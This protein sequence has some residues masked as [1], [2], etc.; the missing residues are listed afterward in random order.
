MSKLYKNIFIILLSVLP[1]FIPVQLKAQSE[2]YQ[3]ALWVR[4]ISN[5]VNWNNENKIQ[6]FTIGVYGSNTSVYDELLKLSKR[7]KIKGKPFEVIRFKRIKDIIPTQI[8]FVDQS[9]NDYLKEIY[10][11]IMFNTLLITDQSNQRNYFMVNLLP[12]SSGKKRV[13]LN[14]KLANNAGLTFERE[15]LV[16]GGDELE[17]RRMISKTEKALEREKKKLE[18]QK[19][20][21]AKQ[22]AELE[23]LK[24]E[25]RKEREENARQK[26][27]NKKQKAE[28]E[29][30]KQLLET[31]REELAKVLENLTL[32][33]EKLAMGTKVLAEQEDKMKEQEDLMLQ[34]QKELE[35][36]EAEIERSKEIIKTKDLTL[37]EQ[38]LTI[39]YQ[40]IILFVFI[41]LL[42]LIMYLAFSIWRSAKMRKKI[43]DELRERN[44]DIR[45]KNEEI[46]NQQRQTE[47][48][49]KELEKLSIVAARTD[50]AVTIMDADGNFE[51]V[52]VGFTRLYGYTLQLLTHE[53]GENIV[54]VSSSSNIK[55]LL[56]QCKREKKTVTYENLNKT[57]NGKE[58]WVQTSLT[59]ILDAEGN[60]NKLITIETNIDRIKQAEQEI[61]KQ[62]KKILEQ[63][64]ILEETNKELEKLSIVASETDNAITIMDAAGNYQWINDGFTRMFGYTFNQLL[65][66]YSRNIISRHTGKQSVELI[67]K[68]IEQVVPVTYETPAETREGKEIWVQTTITPITDKEGNV[69]NLISISTDISK[70]KEAEQAI[71]QQSEEL[72]AQKEE[73]MIKNEYIEQQNEN[74]KASITYAKTIQNAILPAYDE[75]TRFFNTFI[76][77]KPKDIVSGDFF[78]YSHLPEKDGYSEKFFYAAVD[79]TG[80]G[81]PGAFMSMIGSRL[82]NEIVNERKITKPSLILTQ[83]D[84]EVKTI[85]RQEETDNNDG[86]DVSLCMIERLPDNTSRILFAGAKRPLFYYLKEEQTLRYIKG[87]R[88]TIG[89]TQARRNRELFSDNELILKNGDVIYLTTDGLID[90]SSP[91]RIRY[92]TPRLIQLLQRISN[93]PLEEQK[94]MIEKSLQSFQGEEDQRDDVTFI[95]IQL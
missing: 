8:L 40:R 19:K 13:E 26:E 37:G 82:L 36:V 44:D 85:L 12:Q 84:E 59:P 25:N 31:Q 48:L 49:N 23:R 58:V 83:M 6:K 10:D 52:N 15:L 35:Q 73:L 30:Q 95:G 63:S 88:K 53:L 57:R 18:A 86:M 5:Y 28:I 91:Q 32:Q 3:K 79:C 62:H 46:L 42:I 55:D 61:R 27:I 1:M 72:L 24:R 75:I 70:L 93:L 71:R 20:E 65:N 60:I 2:A 7:E 29:E 38:S 76:I 4:N 41:G 17:L 9:A 45:R 78:W 22:T 21:L 92:G 87:T 11:Q 69:K 39:K 33:Q 68:C 43:N 47:M 34:K 50:N 89:G 90:Q 67:K 94:I 14:K 66:E 74:I 81:V 56:E 16:Y 64:K 54:H 77:Y 80:H 51:W